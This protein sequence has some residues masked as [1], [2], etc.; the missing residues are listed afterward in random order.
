MPALNIRMVH[1]NL[2]NLNTKAPESPGGGLWEAHNKKRFFKLKTLRKSLRR[3]EDLE[4]LKNKKWK[5]KKQELVVGK[6]L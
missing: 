6:K 5:S 4:G 1:N 3:A 2:K